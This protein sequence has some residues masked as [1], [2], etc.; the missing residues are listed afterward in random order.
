MAALLPDH[1]PPAPPS[2]PPPPAPS[3]SWVTRRRWLAGAVTAALV[4]GGIAL[5]Q[6]VIGTVIALFVLIVPFEKLFPRHEQ[7]VRRPELGTDLAHAAAGGPLAV[8]GLLIGGAIALLSLAWVP[9]LLLRPLVLALP[10]AASLGAGFLLFDLAVYW[11]HRFAHEV[12]FWWRF[13]KIHH[14]TKRL[15]WI[16][17]VRNHPIDGVIGAPAFVLLIVSGFSLQVSGVLLIAQTIVGLFLHANVRWR[18][19]PLHRIVATPEFHHWHHSNER[20]AHHTNYSGFLPLWDVLFGTY[21]MPAD[22][23]PSVYGIDEELPPGIVGQLWAPMQ[24]LRSVRIIVRHPIRTLEE[25][26]AAVKR[27]LGQMKASAT[28]RP[29]RPLAGEQGVTTF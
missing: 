13:H 27:G 3:P 12:P 9:A 8:I 5:D 4:I 20:A 11:T 23:R 14:S 21:R 2:P 1:T 10:P 24:G 18:L 7:R 15:D 16:S 22:Q 17:G 19:R 29:P 25:T 28:R 26:V 6:E